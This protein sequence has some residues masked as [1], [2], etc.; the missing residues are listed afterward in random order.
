MEKTTVHFFFQ[1]AAAG[2]IAKRQIT[3][4]LKENSLG[5]NLGRWQIGER[6]LSKTAAWTL[7]QMQGVDLEI[8]PREPGLPSFLPSSGPLNTPVTQTWTHSNAH[9]FCVP[10]SLRTYERK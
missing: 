5:I 9:T 8:N 3:T 1:L 7:P 10:P 2:S 6:E 4:E